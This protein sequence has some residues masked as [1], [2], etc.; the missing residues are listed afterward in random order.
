MAETMI[1][2]K[3]GPSGVA[4]PKALHYVVSTPTGS[5]TP[6]EEVKRII[7]KHPKYNAIL[8]GKKLQP[9]ASPGKFRIV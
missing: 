3:K 9:M 2:V 1:E 7:D 4:Q 5:K 6:T 8:K